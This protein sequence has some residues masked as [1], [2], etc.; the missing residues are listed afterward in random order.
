[1]AIEMRGDAEMKG[2]HIKTS[3]RIILILSHKD[4]HK[5]QDNKDYQLLMISDDRSTITTSVE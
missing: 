5:Q 3:T 1:M 4:K 2:A